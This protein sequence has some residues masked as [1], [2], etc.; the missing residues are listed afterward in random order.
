M[1]PGVLV[2]QKVLVLPEVLAGQQRKHCF[3]EHR[4][5]AGWKFGGL[6]VR[7]GGRG[8]SCRPTAHALLQPTCMLTRPA[9]LTAATVVAG[10]P[11][12]FELTDLVIGRWRSS[13]MLGM[14]LQVHHP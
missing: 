12:P 13:W 2:L 1:L 14:I 4:L 6:K 7:V 10:R 3:P 5:S 11:T 9:P 8:V